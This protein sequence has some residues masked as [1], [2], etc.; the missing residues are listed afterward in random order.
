MFGLPFQ[1]FAIIAGATGLII[2]ILLV[3]GLRFK[4]VTGG[5]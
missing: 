5:D 2:L 1:S 4:E 3:W